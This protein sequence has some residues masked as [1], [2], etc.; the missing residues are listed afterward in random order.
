MLSSPSIDQVT[1]PLSPFPLRSA[2]LGILLEI[3]IKSLQPP[4]HSNSQLH[5]TSSTLPP[6]ASRPPLTGLHLLSLL[7][8]GRIADFHTT[9]EALAGEQDGDEQGGLLKDEFVMW[10][11][12]LYV[13]PLFW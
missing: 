12:D 10:P 5:L 7:S 3:L 8:S 13:Y 9:L 6:S 11:V 1:D 4:D 2:L